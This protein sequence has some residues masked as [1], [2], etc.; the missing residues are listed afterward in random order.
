MEL[1]NKEFAKVDKVDLFY[2]TSDDSSKGVADKLLKDVEGKGIL[3]NKGNTY[4][5]DFYISTDGLYYHDLNNVDKFMVSR[6]SLLN[7][8]N[9]A[10][11]TLAWDIILKLQ[12]FISKK[13]VF[14]EELGN[15]SDFVMDHSM[16][17]NE[18]CDGQ[19]KKL[20]FDENSNSFKNDFIYKTDDK[21]LS[22]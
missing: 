15:L 10:G 13:Q 22:K 19:E 12:P 17:F 5:G 16:D 20:I 9:Y 8:L 1:V 7:A 3:T 14:L 6:K 21:K 18:F 4:V 2:L 11:Y